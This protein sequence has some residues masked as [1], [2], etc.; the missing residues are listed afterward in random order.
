MHEVKMANLVSPG[1]QVQLIDESFYA[2]AGPGTVPFIMLAT[3][4]DKA[5]PGNTTAIA[6]GT[7]KANAGKLYNITSQRELI[8]TF[9]NPRFLT[10]AGT[11]Q[12]G[13]ELNEWGLYAAYQYLGLANRAFVIRADVDLTALDSSSQP[14]SG[15][16]RNGSLWL[17]TEN[18]SWG[19]FRSNGN[20]NSSLAWGAIQPIVID[21]AAQLEIQVQ[22]QT[23]TEILDPNADLLETGTL[24]VQPF[25]LQVSVVGTDSLLDVVQ[26][27]NSA[28]AASTNQSVKVLRAEVAERIYAYETGVTPTHEAA[29]IYNLRLIHLN[30]NLDTGISFTGSTPGLLTA[31]GLTV[32]PINQIQPVSSLGTVGSIAVNAYKSRNTLDQ[33]VA[34]V[35]MFEK[36][37]V[38]TNNVTEA[39][40]FLIGSTDT[41]SPGAGWREATPT[42]VTGT[43]RTP[44]ITPGDESEITIGTT[45][46]TFTNAA[47]TLTGLVSQLNEAFAANNVL[48]VA[49]IRTQGPD[50][51]LRITNYEGSDIALVDM[52]GGM[53]DGVGISQTQTFFQDVMG[54]ADVTSTVFA[55]D[56]KLIITVGGI[57]DTITVTDPSGWTAAEFRDAINAN[58]TLNPYMEASL[59][60]VGVTERFRLVNK[61]GT[62]FQLR[63]GVN[64]VAVTPFTTLTGI[65]CAATLG[66]QL[67]YQGYTA[68]QPQP[69]RVDQTTAGNIWINTN[70]G[71]RGSSWNMNRYN[72]GTD[73]WQ[74]RV[75][76]L[77]EDDASANAAYGSQRTPGSLYVQFNSNL[78][79][80]VTA[81][82]VVKAWTG[83][84]WVAT[85]SYTVNN[86]AVPYAQSG[87][88]PRAAPEA[89]A[90]WF[91][92][93]LR[94]DVMVSDGTQ[95]RGY[96][97][98]YPATDPNGVIL[99][100]T[101]PSTQSDGFSP[102]MDQDLWIDTSDLENYPRMY[103]YDSFNALWTL[104]DV[105][106]Q[107]SSQGVVF[108]DVR[109]N[110][111][112]EVSG[113]EDISLMLVSDYVDP[114]APSALTYPYGMLVFNMRYSSNNVK[115]WTP[116]HL[117]TGTW[118]DRWVTAS[119]VTTT[120]APYM[121]RK[122]QRRMVVQALQA[123]VVSNQDIRAE[124]NF[125]N[126]MAAPGYPELIDELVTLNTDKKDV[127]FVLI[128][129][130]ARLMPD[131]TSMQT[132][133]LN[134]N[135]AATNGE[136]GLITRSRYAS[137]YYPWGLAT[138]LD[139]NE[140]FVPPSVA[141]LRT[142]AFNDQVSYPWFAPAGFNRGLVSVLSSVGYLNG[143]NEYVPVQLNQGQ[144]D[145]MYENDVNPIRFIPGRGLVIY[146][147]KTLSPVESA[148]NRV[149]VARLVNYLNYQLDNLAKPFLFEPNDEYTRDSVQRTFESFMGDLVALRAVYDYAVLCDESNNTPERIDRNELW[150]DVAVKPT[151]AV[152]MIY[153]PIRILNTG[154]PLPT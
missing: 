13:S 120:G 149:N 66:N 9:G 92:Q 116:N 28:V 65:P 140:V 26:K 58:V 15:E 45:T 17:D 117:D 129:P 8:Q 1:V 63:N 30:V 77:Y 96:R 121:G 12:Y 22:G 107:T 83:T 119:G 154:D 74:S 118:R 101:E 35:Q 69:R 93:D 138:N 75:A 53:F 139:G 31:L 130:P 48:A 87:T 16:P 125:F 127:A 123:A 10:Q 135:N 55:P 126:L 103:R 151:K 98:L 81:T 88:A 112:G 44:S 94:V 67:V 99:S 114:D 29:T 122:A 100:A 4:Q 70:A 34:Q 32:T 11:P 3:A 24:V 90:L 84:A 41:Q 64:A 132:W 23:T 86:Q 145:V 46:F 143:E 136:D 43:D 89:G 109:P 7:V 134:Q 131:G 27:I 76:P 39:R 19:M 153:I 59:V 97:N 108:A 102:L 42:V 152:E 36:I 133:A 18:T 21:S 49:S 95:W 128:D 141:V 52:V 71:N 40:W 38:T 72:A 79:T 148:L 110:N 60:A 150:I 73:T 85:H 146:G 25:N 124:G 62:F 144:S 33:L 37:L 54:A 82:L 104:I 50:A 113:S 56:T 61:Q 105:T 2:G 78:T 5:Q 142:Y 106:D 51:Y 137:V 91:N 20:I 57:T 80:P 68:Q 14:P 6:P 115:A 147:Q 47:T 111:N